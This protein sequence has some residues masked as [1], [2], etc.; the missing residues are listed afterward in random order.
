[1]FPRTNNGSGS[2]TSAASK[3]G[4]SYSPNSNRFR[5][6][7]HLSI[8]RARQPA[9]IPKVFR[10]LFVS[11]TPGSCERPI[12]DKSIRGEYWTRFVN[13]NIIPEFSKK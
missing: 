1:M 6:N 3:S 13:T 2:K 4:W 8:H 12:D 5:L 11:D 10:L 7:K 9:S